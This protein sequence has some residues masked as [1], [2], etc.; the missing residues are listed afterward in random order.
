MGIAIAD[1]RD[2]AVEWDVEPF[3]T[4]RHPAIG[5]FDPVQTAAILA[6]LALANKPNAPSM[7]TQA[8]AACAIG[9]R[10]AKASHS[11]DVQIG[12]VQDHDRGTRFF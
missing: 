9:M 5:Q 2:P 1:H 8:P 10:S 4:V 11:A 12:G 3:V 7:W 6:R